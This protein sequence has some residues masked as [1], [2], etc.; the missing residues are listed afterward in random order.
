MIDTSNPPPPAK[1][2]GDVITEFNREWTRDDVPFTVWPSDNDW[3]IPLLDINQQAQ[4]LDLPI[5]HWGS[6]SR[7]KKM[8]GTLA[9]YTDDYRFEALASDPSPVANLSIVN[10][11]EPNFTTTSDMPAAVAL[12]QIFRKRYMTRWWQSIGIRA[13]VDMNVSPA[14]Y[15]LNMLGV[16]KGWRAYATRGSADFLHWLDTEYEIAC[17]WAES[18]DILFVVFAGGKAVKDHCQVK[19]YTW[20]P[21]RKDL[22]RGLY[23]LG[24]R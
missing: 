10:V 19:G 15:D 4:S 13:F 2:Q 14:F 7:R 8:R 22:D 16:P 11:V 3:G 9:F 18:K 17:E 20:I 1:P 6:T 12:Y 23:D 21:D 24:S 5:Q